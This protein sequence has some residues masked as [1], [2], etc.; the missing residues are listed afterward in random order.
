[1]TMLLL[2]WRRSYRGAGTMT[3]YLDKSS[4]KVVMKLN[5]AIS[6]TNLRIS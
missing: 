3:N 1:M 2:S 6:L 4:H 5:T